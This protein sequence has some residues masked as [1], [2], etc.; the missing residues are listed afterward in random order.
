MY[1]FRSSS[2]TK[3]DYMW[4]M[5]KYTRNMSNCFAFEVFFYCIGVLSFFLETTLMVCIQFFY[6]FSSASWYKPRP[7]WDFQMQKPGIFERFCSVSLCKSQKALVG[8]P[9]AVF[10]CLQLFHALTHYQE[11]FQ[12]HRILLRNTSLILEREVL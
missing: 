3:R 10:F 7:F 5:R 8:S 9:K 11:V 2:G 1:N 4:Y 6:S 12:Y